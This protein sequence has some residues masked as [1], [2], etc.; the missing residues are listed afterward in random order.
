MVWSDYLPKRS[1]LGGTAGYMVGGRP[2]LVLAQVQAFGPQSLDLLDLAWNLT[3][4]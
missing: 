1:L 2:N 3:W 4:T